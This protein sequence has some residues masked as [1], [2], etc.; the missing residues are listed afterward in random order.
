[1]KLIFGNWKMNLTS[2]ASVA[3]AAALAKE[4]KIQNSKFKTLAVGVFP[5]FDAL[6][7]VHD[8][9]EGS[10]IILGAQD[11]FWEE[12]GADTGEESPA[13]IK[14][15]GC[16]HVLVGHS[17]RRAKLGETDE[18]VNNKLKA[19]LGAGLTPVLC[20][21]ETESQRMGGQWTVVIES[22]TRKGLAG[23]ELS[24]NRQIV[25]A[26][27]PVWAIGTGKPCAPADAREAHALIRNTLVELFGAERAARHFSVIYGGSVEAKNI[28]SYLR[29]EGIDGALVGGASQKL[30]SFLALIGAA[31]NG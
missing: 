1:M 16:T 31:L 18:M 26:Y 11:C 23:I 25:I 17:E 28:A 22:Q 21:G 30:T 8:A 3:L 9:L 7:K 10:S 13:Q 15:V 27:E 2:A 19:A 24:G 14:A 5:S 6:E 4:F 20:V 29:E 12:K